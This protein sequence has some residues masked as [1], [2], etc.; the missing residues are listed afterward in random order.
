M[1]PNLIFA[2]HTL[3]SASREASP[4]LS[5]YSYSIR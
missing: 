4:H 2:T 5:P 1:R 3:V